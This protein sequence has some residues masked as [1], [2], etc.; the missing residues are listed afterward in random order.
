MIM[1]QLNTHMSESV[2]RLVA[3]ECGINEDSL[4]IKGE[5]G[6]LKSKS[7]RKEFLEDSTHKIQFLFTPK[8]TSWMNQIEIWFSIIGRQLLNR[9]YSFKSV[10]E[11]EE[12]IGEYIEYYNNYVA[13]P[14]KWSYTGKLLKA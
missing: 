13:K 12:K 9:R 3:C 10:I 6:I 7:S 4:G 14:Y 1:D 5:S 11:L 2:V 8:H